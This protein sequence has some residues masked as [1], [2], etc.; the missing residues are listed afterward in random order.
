MS[1]ATTPF[2][3][4]YRMEVKIFTEDGKNEFEPVRISKMTTS[5]NYSTSF[6]PS[7]M[8]VLQLTPDQINI[9]K[10]NE[11]T[12]LLSMKLSKVKFINDTE[13]AANRKEVESELIYDKVFVPIVE[14]DDVVNIR[15]FKKLNEGNIADNEVSGNDRSINIFKV[16]MYLNTV[17]YHIMYKKTYNTVLRGADNGRI[18]IDT[19]LRFICETTHINGYIIDKPDNEI[20]MD[21][22]IIPPGNV[23]YVLDSLQVLYGIYFNDL[24]SFYDID[25]KLYILSRLNKT[26]DYEANKVKKTILSVYPTSDSESAVT[27]LVL[28]ENN[29]T[30]KHTTVKN[31]EDNSLGIASGEAFGDSIIFTNF[32]FS[33]ETFKYANGEISEINPT[34]REYLRNS[35][36]H[37]KTSKGISFEYDELNNSFNMFSNLSSFGISSMYIVKTEGMDLDCLK[38]NV[39]YSISIYGD[40][41]DNSRFVNKEFNLL[42]FTQDFIRDNDIGT[43]DLFKTYE[44]LNLGY[45]SK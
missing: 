44:V 24:T 26:H 20:P 42:E 38:P 10:N 23:K 1:D 40:E 8:I 39:M 7:I 19:A 2:H 15:E 6:T 30:I 5:A 31:L 37:S 25:G 13:T 3:V 33:S 35:I 36:S 4:R 43:G 34:T 41:T 18:T 29:N 45:N 17:D 14:S 16:R 27:G 28:Y 12:I 21:N 11:N 22:I 32:G 9:V